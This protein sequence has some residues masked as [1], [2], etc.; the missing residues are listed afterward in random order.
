[1]I[2]LIK[3]PIIA[4]SLRRLRGR[5]AHSLFAVYLHLKQRA[6]EPS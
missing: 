2:R 1:M 3:K 4:E 6:T 5:K